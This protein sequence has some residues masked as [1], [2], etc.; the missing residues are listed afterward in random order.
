MKTS[1]QKCRQYVET[2]IP[3]QGHN[4]SGHKISDTCYMVQSY[5]WWPLWACIN[6]KWYG[7]DERYSASTSKQRSQSY[8]Y[9]SEPT[10]L[11][12]CQV[13]RNKISEF[14]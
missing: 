3:F 13:L 1:N 10:M 6:G 12:D 9:N 4:L 8:P 14:S 11:D 2:L 5:G 7:H